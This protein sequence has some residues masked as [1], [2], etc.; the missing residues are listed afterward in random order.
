MHKPESVLE[1]ETRKILWDSEIQIDHLFPA[2]RPDLLL[3]LK[4]K[5]ENYYLMNFAHPADHRE[6][7]KDS[8][9]KDKYLDLALEQ[10]SWLNHYTTRTPTPFIVSKF[11]LQSL[12]YIHFRTNT[13]GKGTNSF[14]FPALG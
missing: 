14:F 3:I 13:L 4:K 10:K 9:K 6:K 2:K 8:E 5:W 12:S 11:K 1:K 7:I